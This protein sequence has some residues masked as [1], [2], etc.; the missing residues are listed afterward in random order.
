MTLTAAVESLH[1]SYP[2]KFLTDVRT[3]T[4]EIFDCNPWITPI[5][6]DDPEAIQID[7][8]YSR[9]ITQANR[10]PHNFLGCYTDHLSSVLGI[11]IKL[12]V[13]RPLLYLVDAEKE[14]LRVS[15]FFPK[16]NQK[17]QPIWLI[18]AGS[19]SDYPAKQWPVE[20]FQK[21]VDS[22]SEIRW[23]QIGSD[24]QGEYPHTH[25][26]LDHCDNLVGK[27]GHRDL[28]RL[29]YHAAGCLGGITYLMH[30]AAALEKPYICLAGGREPAT[31]I[32]YPKQ[33]HL[34]TIGQLPCCENQSCWKSR[35]KPIGD[36]HDMPEKLCDR[37]KFDELKMPVGEC[38]TLIHPEEVIAIIRRQS[39][40][41]AT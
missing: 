41:M 40:G 11:P 10:L 29:V 15:R 26:H 35:L 28:H 13:N 30:V 27:T 37:P 24:E 2:G 1:L 39:A 4:P 7:L 12:Q 5:N 36:G 31:W 16:D 33:H 23:V 21:V 8:S 25:P 32:N 17:P 9:Y 34:H 19:K 14:W 22:F 18:C 38:M 6:E 20:Y 3:S